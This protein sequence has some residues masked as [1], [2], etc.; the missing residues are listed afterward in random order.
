VIEIE[1]TK[2]KDFEALTIK[3]KKISLTTIPELGGKII[4]I[5]NRETGFDFIWRNKAIK[6]QKFSYGTNYALSDSSGIDE[7][8]PNIGRGKYIDFPWEN[9]NIPDHG[10]IW[11]LGFKTTVKEDKIIQKV[12][13]VRF[14]YIFNR[15]ISIDDNTIKLSYRVENLSQFKFNFTWAIHPIFKLL[16]DTEI[17]IEGSPDVTVDYST[18]KELILRDK[19][20]IWSVIETEN[21]R[22][23]DFSKVIKG[24]GYAVKFVLSNLSTGVVTLKY[25]DK[26]EKIDT[27]FNK[28]KNK[29]CGL[30][31]NSKGWPAGNECKYNH[32]SIEPGNAIFGSLEE[33]IRRNG[34][35][36][37]EG[38]GQATWDIRF[39]I[40]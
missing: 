4:S 40:Y 33:C 24:K 15:E 27:I 3:N 1:E 28:D 38:G 25:G 20:Y 30:W 36:T 31:L 13:G 10:E 18:D 9:I 7:L 34:F 17:I 37:I 11:S 26:N 23:I 16:N 32:I 8:F 19:K 14:P 21:S 22:R 29:Y 6:L 2:F 5:V 12:C 35:G 39:N